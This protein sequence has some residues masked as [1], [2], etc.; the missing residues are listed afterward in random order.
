MLDNFEDVMDH[1]ALTVR[2]RELEEAPRMALTYGDPH[3]VKVILTTR[4]VPET[5]RR[6]EDT[7]EML[8]GLP[9]AYA[10][11]MLR[12]MDAD[13]KVGIQSTPDEL[14]REAVR[15]T[16]GNPH[17]LETLFGI[18]AAD[19]KTTLANL[20]KTDI[21]SLLGEAFSR[22][23]MTAKRVM[24]ALAIYARPVRADAVDYLIKPYEPN[25]AVTQVLRRLVNAYLVRKGPK[26]YFLDGPNREYALSQIPRGEPADRESHSGSVFSQFALHHAAANYFHQVRRPRERW[27]QTQLSEFRHRCAAEEFNLAAELLFAIDMDYLFLWGLYWQAAE[28]HERLQGKLTEPALIERRSN[29]GYST[30]LHGHI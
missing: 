9:E 7:L 16:Q 1:E 18:L 17:R 6:V 10:E 19:K 21:E 5:L 13:G 3:G 14:L 30:R 26:G 28:L 8:D 11:S 20:L 27:I 22:H 24:Q 2:D 23:S 4:F 12:L 15:R 25:E 29:I